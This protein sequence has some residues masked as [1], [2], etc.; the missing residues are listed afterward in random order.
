MVFSSM[1]FPLP[2]PSQSPASLGGRIRGFSHTPAAPRATV[3]PGLV[4]WLIWEVLHPCLL[5]ERLQ[6]FS[7]GILGMLRN[8]IN[9][10]KVTSLASGKCEPRTKSLIFTTVSSPRLQSLPL[11]SDK[12]EWL[13][14]LQIILYFRGL[15]SINFQLQATP[16]HLKTNLI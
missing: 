8:S 1:K 14:S 13:F 11:Q 16:V 6:I 7:W 15:L 3:T 9:L 5:N 2:E 10:P 12:W 4:S